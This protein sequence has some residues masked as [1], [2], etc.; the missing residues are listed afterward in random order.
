MM[1]YNGGDWS[2]AYEL[3]LSGNLLPGD[4]FIV[5]DNG[6]SSNQTNSTIL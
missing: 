5:S 1:I 6:T 2:T 3:V 4:V